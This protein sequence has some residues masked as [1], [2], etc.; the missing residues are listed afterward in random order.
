VGG[1]GG[2]AAPHSPPRRRDALEQAFALSQQITGDPIEDAKRRLV[3]TR[4]Y[5]NRWVESA[6]SWMGAGQWDAG[7]RT[8]LELPPAGGTVAIE[9]HVSG[10]PFG[11]VLA[12]ADDAGDVAI[13][14]RVFDRRADLWAWLTEVGRDRRGLTLLHPP[15]YKGHVPGAIRAQ[16]VQVGQAEQYSGYGPTVAAAL[17]GRILHDGDAE[18]RKHV[19]SAGTVRIPDRGTA[20]SSKHSAGPIF[21]ARAMVWAVAHELRPDAGR[22]AMVVSGVAQR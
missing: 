9:H 14:A 2:G 4:Q 7:A 1:G 8:S 19:L 13:A 12:V 16:L 17:E 15:G 6:S 22:R 3:W 21:L 10:Y 18:L 20:L 11:A 5:L